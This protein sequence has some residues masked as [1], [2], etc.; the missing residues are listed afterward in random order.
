[1]GTRRGQA[2]IELAIGLFTFALVA[3]ALCGFAVYIARSLRVQNTQRGTSPE[4]PPPVEIGQFA[5]DYVFGTQT[6]K[7]KE[8]FYLPERTILK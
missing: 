1:M 4:S 5:A 2:L 6:L 8:T 3:T 7:V